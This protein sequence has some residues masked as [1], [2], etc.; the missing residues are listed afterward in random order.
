MN[1]HPTDV[2]PITLAEHSYFFVGTEYIEAGGRTLSQGS[3]YVEKFAPVEQKHVTPVVMIHGFGQTGVNFIGTPDGRRGWMHDFLRA[4]YTV[5]VVDQS[6]RGRSGHSLLQ[7]QGGT[8]FVEDVD[9]VQNYFTNISARQLWPQARHHSQW[10]G[11]GQVG[12]PVFDQFYASQVDGL[13]DRSQTEHMVRNAGAELLDKVGPAI[14]LTHSQAG[15][16][17]WLIADVRPRLV[18]AILSV[19]P[20]GPPFFDVLYGERSYKEQQPW[21]EYNLQLLARPYG[22]TRAPLTFDPPLAEDEVLAFELQS[23]EANKELVTGYLQTSPARQLPNLHGIP[24]L[25]MV[26]QASYHAPYDHLTSDFLT[27]AGVDN[28]LVYLEQL[29]CTGNGHMV[30][31]E[32]NNHAVADIL[33]SWLQAHYTDE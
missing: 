26:T 31:N 20:N 11:S 16:I 8:L 4:G 23:V 15:S 19:E 27:Q 24:I 2:E 13:S 17:G 6:A 22:I 32:K 33:I 21:H 12:D 5:Y 9:K 14:L 3:M 25:I 10:P 18:Q 1:A 29:G 28:D 30:M 7:I